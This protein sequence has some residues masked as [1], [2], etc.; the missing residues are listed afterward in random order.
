M[1]MPRGPYSG[2]W[3]RVGECRGLFGRLVQGGHWRVKCLEAPDIGPGRCLCDS[4][5]GSLVSA[6]ICSPSLRLL[7]GAATRPR[8]LSALLNTRSFPGGLREGLG[9]AARGAFGVPITRTRRC[10]R[11]RKVSG[12]AGAG[13]RVACRFSFLGAF[14]RLVTRVLF[15]V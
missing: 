9:G 7:A 12:G 8:A 6:L 13:V 1:E 15:S 5:R 4:I 10:W 14:T 11:R 3:L 2:L